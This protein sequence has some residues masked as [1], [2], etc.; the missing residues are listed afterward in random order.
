MRVG[1]AVM[2]GVDAA[3][4]VR[5][6]SFERGIDVGIA[7]GTFVGAMITFAIGKEELVFFWVS[8]VI[9]FAVGDARRVVGAYRVT[10]EDLVTEPFFGIL[11][12]N[13]KPMA[14]T[15]AMIGTA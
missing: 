13:I 5:Y 11:M 7:V 6:G 4:A 15:P 1:A 10:E 3:E 2:N 8:E 14:T 12:L 9:G